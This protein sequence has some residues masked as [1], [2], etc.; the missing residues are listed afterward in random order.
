MTDCSQCPSTHLDGRFP[1]RS[2]LDDF[3]QS[4]A[5]RKA[6]SLQ[7]V[8]PAWSSS[9][10]C[11]RAWRDSS[12]P[13]RVCSRAGR[14]VLFFR[15]RKPL[16]DGANSGAGIEH[17]LL[18][19]FLAGQLFRFLVQATSSSCMPPVLMEPAS[20]PRPR[21]AVKPA[22][23]A[24]RALRFPPGPGLT[25][26]CCRCFAGGAVRTASAIRTRRCPPRSFLDGALFSF[27]GHG[28]GRFNFGQALGQVFDLGLVQH[29]VFFKVLQRRLGFLEFG[30]LSFL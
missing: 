21:S 26:D 17:V 5:L 1:A 8:L 2:H 20:S 16:W 14:P 28:Q 13:S 9:A 30:F 29:H 6:L 23:D 25:H 11:C 4:G 19:L 18:L 22:A 24:D 12:R 10:A 27:T 7:P 15:G 3:G